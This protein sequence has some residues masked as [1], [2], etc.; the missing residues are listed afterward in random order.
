MPISI[1][2]SS[3]IWHYK[4]PLHLLPRRRID[5]IIGDYPHLCPRLVAAVTVTPFPP[6]ADVCHYSHHKLRCYTAVADYAELCAELKAATKE[7]R[8]TEDL[9]YIMPLIGEFETSG[10]P[11]D[12]F[13]QRDAL[14]AVAD[15]IDAK[16]G[17]V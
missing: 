15:I 16:F 5:D 7:I 4:K 11:D 12:D 6:K 3:V 14:R 17:K 1:T 9:Q 2:K 13:V 10:F 8:R